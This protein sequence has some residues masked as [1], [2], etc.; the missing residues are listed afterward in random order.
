MDRGGDTLG[1]KSLGQVTA[2]GRSVYTA[3][4]KTSCC[5][6]RLVPDKHSSDFGLGGLWTSFLIQHS[7][8]TAK[9][10]EKEA[11]SSVNDAIR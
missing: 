2:I 9:V 11:F 5:E 7:G 1:D 3:Q 4:F 6:K 10:K 8:P